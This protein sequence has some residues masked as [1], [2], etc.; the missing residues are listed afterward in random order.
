MT[1][2]TRVPRRPV[3]LVLLAV[4]AV[5]ASAL[6]PAAATAGVKPCNGSS[7]LCERPFNLVTLPGSHNSMS[8]AGQNWNMPNQTYPIP[9]QLRRGARA[10]LIDT[11]YGRPVTVAGKP[12]VQDVQ[13]ANYNPAN[14][15]RMYLCHASC[16]MG[17]SDLIEVFGQVSSFLRANPREVLLFDVEDKVK[18]VD[19]A[20]AVEESGLVN[21]AYRGPTTDPDGWPTL[22]E[23]VR[24]GQRVVF[25]SEQQD[26]GMDVPWYHRGYSGTLQETP[27]TWPAN[28]TPDGIER[29]TDP[30]L[31]AA[32]CAP[33]RGGT[34]GPLFLMNHWVS[35]SPAM[36]TPS[37]IR[38]W[39]R[40]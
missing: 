12:A 25:L 36:A 17:A 16:G 11:H 35:G 6:V 29:L 39:R 18:P 30:A 13:P 40:S 4:A 32:S 33:N 10:M 15:D 23:M 14:G 31:L 9:E 5:L 21:F 38:Q 34:T 28:E 7:G 1:D 19:F 27:Y 24:T 3:A 20:R 26:G 22:G 37:L 8:N 2:S